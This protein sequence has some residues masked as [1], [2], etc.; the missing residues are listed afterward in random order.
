MNPAR[1]RDRDEDVFLAGQ[2]QRRRPDLA[3]P[4]GRVVVLDHRELGQVGVHRLVHVPHR[5]L[6][7]G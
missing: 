4:V 7:L 1:Q 3:Q 2:H 5:G 6:E